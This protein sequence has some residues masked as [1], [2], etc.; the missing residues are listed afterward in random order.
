MLCVW[1]VRLTQT[2]GKRNFELTR[3]E[4]FFRR[5]K[6]F[7]T[8]FSGRREE[9]FGWKFQKIPALSRSLSSAKYTRLR[10]INVL[11]CLPARKYTAKNYERREKLEERRER[12]KENL[13][14]YQ[15]KKLIKMQIFQPYNLIKLTLTGSSQVCLS[16]PSLNFFSCFLHSTPSTSSFPPFAII[17]GAVSQLTH[18]TQQL[19]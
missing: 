19:R 9:C 1:S 6:I 16:L 8:V 2:K 14:N 10:V 4:K 5:K 3:G 17:V 11:K 12:E 13:V 7:K 15:K 18:H